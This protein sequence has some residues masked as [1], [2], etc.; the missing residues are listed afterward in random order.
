MAAYTYGQSKDVT[1]GIRNSMESNW[2]LNQALSPNN[3]QLATS[4]FDVRN[5]IISTVNYRFAWDKANKYVSSFSLFYSAQSGTPYS[6]GFVGSTING[7]GQTVSLAY[8]PKAGETVNFF[9]DIAGGATAATQAAA[10]DTFIDG[11]K[12]LK[13]RRGISLKETERVHPGIHNLISVLLR[14]SE[15]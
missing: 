5:R 14:I 11:D 6:Y 8:I 9:K 7:T 3:P 4:N 2:Q 12:Y 13:T 1:N 15:S 10:F